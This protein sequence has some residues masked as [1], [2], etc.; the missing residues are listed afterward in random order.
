MG[1]RG[2]EDGKEK[3][4]GKNIFLTFQIHDFSAVDTAETNALSKTGL[5]PSLLGN[6]TYF[7]KVKTGHI[8]QSDFISPNLNLACEILETVSVNPMAADL[9]DLQKGIV[10]VQTSQ[11]RNLMFFKVT[12]PYHPVPGFPDHLNP[13]TQEAEVDH[14]FQASLDYKARLS[15]NPKQKYDI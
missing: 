6:K 10:M 4:R 3:R 11:V 13:S 14:E 5:L 2:N 1:G 12:H 8:I 15:Q 7:I 9:G